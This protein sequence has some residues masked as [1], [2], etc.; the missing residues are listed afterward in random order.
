MLRCNSTGAAC[1]TFCCATARNL[2]Q[3]LAT[4]V[5]TYI[6]GVRDV[7]SGGA[8]P[9]IPFNRLN[10]ACTVEGLYV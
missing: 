1:G 4:E 6:C 9:G 10:L 3:I 2:S 7:L 8:L 5:L